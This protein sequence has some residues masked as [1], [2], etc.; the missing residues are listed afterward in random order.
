MLRFC[1][2]HTN[3]FS[4]FSEFF[5]TE[6]SH[7]RNLKVLDRLFC[8]PL[9]ETAHM[10]K[11][12]IDRLFPNLDEVLTVHT[13]YNQKMKE[14]IKLGFPIGNVGDILSEMVSLEKR[15]HIFGSSRKIDNIIFIDDSTRNVTTIHCF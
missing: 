11:E 14:R 6:R 13:K 12:L 8:R 1:S 9:V 15:A 2:I 5:Q 4:I 3:F 7:V 10:S